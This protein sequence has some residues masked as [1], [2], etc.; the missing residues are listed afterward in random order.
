MIDGCWLEGPYGWLDISINN[1]PS[2]IPY[3]SPHL[4]FDR[5]T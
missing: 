3:F 1:L 2:T 5:S 4:S